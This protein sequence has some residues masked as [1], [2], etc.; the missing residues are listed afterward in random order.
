MTRALSATKG[1]PQNGGG[2]DAKDEAAQLLRDLRKR[3][4]IA[5][6]A[7][8]EMPS[9]LD[10]LTARLLPLWH[11]LLQEARR[12]YRERKR[13]AALLDFDDLER[14]A[15]D[16]LN[17]E[18][19]RARYRNAEFKHLLVDEFQDTNEAQWR[20]ISQLADMETAG[21]LFTVGDPKQSIY[22]FRGAD[23][24]VFNAVRASFGDHDACLELPLSMSFRSHYN[25]VE[26]FNALFERL[27]IRNEDS[28]AKQY[29]VAFHKPMKAF[30]EES[31]GIPA[32]EL[33]LLDSQIRDKSGEPVTRQAKARAALSGGK[34]ASLGSL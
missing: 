6:D 11:A 28:P 25:L 27:L 13:S 21:S 34:Y 18:A 7:I 24:S 2:K 30:R 8:S 29:E 3:V 23:V 10:R 32:I 1:R 12:T 16:L 17:D 26:Q 4:K 22:Q 5:L 9:D 19:V 31:P 15:A 14:L 33:Q 20:I